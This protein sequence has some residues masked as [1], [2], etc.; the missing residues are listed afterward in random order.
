M[1]ASAHSSFTVIFS[2]G[3]FDLS[4]INALRIALCVFS[5]LRSMISSLAYHFILRFRHKLP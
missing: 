4:S 2:S 3:F 5:I 1:H